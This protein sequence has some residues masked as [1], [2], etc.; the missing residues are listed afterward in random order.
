LALAASRIVVETQ[1]AGFGL[2]IAG[3][4]SVGDQAVHIDVAGPNRYDE[5]SRF[6]TMPSQLTSMMEQ[7]RAFDVEMLVERD[8]GM[9]V[10]D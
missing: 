1:C 10:S 4:G 6:D 7:D 5:P 9:L 8:A 3:G 2:H